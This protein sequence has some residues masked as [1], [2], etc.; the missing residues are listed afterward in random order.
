MFAEIQRQIPGL[1]TRASG[2]TAAMVRAASANTRPRTRRWLAYVALALFAGSLAALEFW[3]ERNSGE[4]PGAA[5][6]FG[7]Q[8]TQDA[9][10]DALLQHMQTHR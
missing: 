1:R 10:R 7:P 9:I 5:M 2:S 3:Y 4:T 6:C 8:A